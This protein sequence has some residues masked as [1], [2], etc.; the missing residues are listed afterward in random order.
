M[1]S[2]EVQKVLEYYRIQN[3]VTRHD[4]SEKASK[5]YT[6]KI[7]YEHA[8]W[9][10]QTDC[11]LRSRGQ[12]DYALFSDI[13]EITVGNSPTGHLGPALD[14]CM[15]AKEKD[16]KIA[17]SF[18]SNTVTSVYTKLNDKEE[19]FFSDK[20]LLERYSKMEASPH[21][22]ANCA[23]TGPNCRKY[24][25][26]R[27]K[28]MVNV[29]DTSISPQ[30]MWTHAISRDYDEM[31]KIMEILD[32]DLIHVRHFQGHW[33]LNKDLLNDMEEKYAP[34][35][36]NVIKNIYTELKSMGDVSDTYWKARKEASY[37]GLPWIKPVERPEKYR[38]QIP[39]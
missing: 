36:A 21:C 29:R 20:L 31:D 33:Y 34:L 23:C 38:P 25:Q 14:A 3:F 17:C 12:F 16:N 32:D 37:S 4:W 13:D 24:H 9:A 5:E 10:A 2:P 11:A 15:A 39:S 30:P 27:Q 8:K 6:T 35:E 7:T 18:N 22:P 19:K 28:Y 1:H 26:G